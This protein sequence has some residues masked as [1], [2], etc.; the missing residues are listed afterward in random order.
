MIPLRHP[1]A[2]RSSSLRPLLLD[3]ALDVEVASQSLDF[4][5]PPELEAHEP[6]EERGIQRDEVRMMVSSRG[7]DDILHTRFN[8]LPDLLSA[9]DVIVINTSG[10]MAAALQGWRETGEKIEFHLSTRLPGGIWTVELRRLGEAGTVPLSDDLRGERISLCGGGV[11][12]IHAPYIGDRSG[13]S[14]YQSP[15]TPMEHYRLW[16]ATL[17]LPL[18]LAEY[19]AHYGFPIRYGY[20]T[21]PWPIDY[22]RTT[23]QTEV[24]SAEMPSAGRPFTPEVI[25]RLVA[26]GVIVAP[27]LLH[28]G[29]ASPEEH[30]PPYEEYYRIPRSTAAIVNRALQ[31]HRRVIA[32]GTTVV[33]G[34]ESV[35][36]DRGLL[37]AGEGWTRLVIAPGDRVR[38]VS[39]LLTGLH[40]PRASHLA[41]LEAV[42]GR[43]QL[44]R[45][46]REALREKYLWHEFG[47]VHLMSYAPTT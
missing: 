14:P 22:Y 3:P 5:L 33:R 7:S 39:G 10:T 18:P 40:E 2:A 19:L 36:D 43:E 35:V 32:V 21:R 46:Y 26:Q 17:E 1:T 15:S 6:P 30:E 23:F 41:M 34:L 44:E 25:T 8:A 29:V 13:V 37:H 45:S 9:G 27:M 42:G 4:V 31:E 12:T 28:T 24:G 11:A 20:I 38:S 47:D 16:S